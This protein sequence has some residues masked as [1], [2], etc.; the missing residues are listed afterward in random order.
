MS[1]TTDLKQLVINTV[2]SQEVYHY[3][4]TNGLINEDEIY[5]VAGESYI[6]PIASADS[7]GGVKVGSGLSVEA[8]G[9]ISFS[10]DID[11]GLFTDTTTNRGD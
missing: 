7:L 10:G 1:T 2:E 3:L 8:D 11:C 4:K 5:L 9:T 6:L